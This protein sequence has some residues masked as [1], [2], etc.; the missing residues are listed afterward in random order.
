M[1]FVLTERICGWFQNFK[2]HFFQKICIPRENSTH[3]HFRSACKLYEIELI[4]ILTDLSFVAW[5][6]KTSNHFTIEKGEPSPSAPLLTLS[7][8]CGFIPLLCLLTPTALGW[9]CA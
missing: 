5:C 8:P 9:D 2:Q 6:K 7:S 1:S 4:V 3:H